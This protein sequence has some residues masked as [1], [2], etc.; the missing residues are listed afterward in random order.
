VRKEFHKNRDEKD[1]VKIDMLKTG[2]VRAL[3]N[4]LVLESSAKDNKL[5]Q[6]ALRYAKDQAETIKNSP[7]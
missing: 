3:S 7:S 5:Q 1:P 6:R 2:A 4:Y